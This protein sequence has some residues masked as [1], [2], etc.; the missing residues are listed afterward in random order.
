MKKKKVFS[1][2][3]VHVASNNCN[4]IL[5]G[6]DNEFTSKEGTKYFDKFGR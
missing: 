3:T 2:G 4:L 1:N 6:N 5:L